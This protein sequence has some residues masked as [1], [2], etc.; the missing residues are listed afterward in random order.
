MDRNHFLMAAAA[1]VAVIAIAYFKA[2]AN[3]MKPEIVCEYN[4]Q[5]SEFWEFDTSPNE[6][7]CGWRFSTK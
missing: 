1:L 7:T 2:N 5:G 3:E 4:L 6:I